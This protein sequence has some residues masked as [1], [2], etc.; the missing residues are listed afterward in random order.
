MPDIPRSL[1]KAV[2]LHHLKFEIFSLKI[3]AYDF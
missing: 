2:E 3:T 1:W